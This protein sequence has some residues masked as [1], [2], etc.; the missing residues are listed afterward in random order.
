MRKRR[1]LI[2]TSSEEDV[3][4]LPKKAI[5]TKPRK[6]S[7]RKS[8]KIVKPQSYDW[9]EYDSESESNL[10]FVVSDSWSEDSDYQTKIKKSSGS[11]KNHHQKLQKNSQRNQ[12]NYQQS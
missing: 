11:S 4:E 8:K 6:K 7:P 12:H 5:K 2:Y 10:S 1:V 3:T 9:S